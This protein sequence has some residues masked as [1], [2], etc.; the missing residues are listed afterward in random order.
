M[1]SEAIKDD[2]A[3]VN[4][5]HSREPGDEAIGAPCAYNNQPISKEVQ[6]VIYE[7]WKSVCE[8]FQLKEDYM[9]Q[10]LYSIIEN[11]VRKGDYLWQ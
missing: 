2:S 3:L 7:R 6:N 5:M 8:H 10:S 9:K 1:Q 11:Q 4:P